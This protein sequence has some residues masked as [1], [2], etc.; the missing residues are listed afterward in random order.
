VTSVRAFVAAAAAIAY[1]SSLVGCA[2]RPSAPYTAR[3]VDAANRPL[4]EVQSGGH[5]VAI[6]KPGQ[7]YQVEVSNNTDD[8]VGVFLSIDGLDGS[9]GRPAAWEP[10]V[11]VYRSAH[12][13]APWTYNTLEGFDL[14]P[15]TKSSYGF[16]DAGHSYAAQTGVTAAIGRIEVGFYGRGRT[17]TIRMT[18]PSRRWLRRPHRALRHRQRASAR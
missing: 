18:T 9:N 13:F 1:A 16:I 14:T 7:V 4:A 11:V 10:A 15:T 2:A 17:R 6:G 3:L 8:P 5:T 12:H